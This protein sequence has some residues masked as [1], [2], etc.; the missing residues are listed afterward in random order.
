M[1]I[2]TKVELCLFKDSRE[3]NHLKLKIP[4]NWSGP[5]MVFTLELTGIIHLCQAFRVSHNLTATRM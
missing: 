5:Y 2:P 1:K 3:I 4:K